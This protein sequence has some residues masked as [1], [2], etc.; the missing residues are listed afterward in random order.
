MQN[1]QDTFETRQWSFITLFKKFNPLL[2]ILRKWSHSF[3]K[4]NKWINTTH[5]V[6]LVYIYHICL[7]FFTFV[8]IRM[9]M[10]KWN[11][12]RCWKHISRV[13]Y[14]FGEIIFFCWIPLNARFVHTN[15]KLHKMNSLEAIL[16]FCRQLWNK[17]KQKGQHI[18]LEFSFFRR[19]C[20]WI[21]NTYV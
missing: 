2:K 9:P 16:V 18:H 13:N 8:F 15:L 20:E 1:F 5:L 21:W 3:E 19:P 17:F 7:C 4:Y 10:K 14:R 6:S 11:E 12:Q